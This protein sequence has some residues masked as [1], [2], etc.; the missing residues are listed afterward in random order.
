MALDTSTAAARAHDE[1]LRRLGPEG[2]V[3]TVCSMSAALREMAE[4]RIR[5][6]HPELDEQG[7]TDQLIF[8]LYGVR[9]PR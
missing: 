9:I 6:S 7:V 3:Q 5:R 2:R 4:D 8:E 1:A